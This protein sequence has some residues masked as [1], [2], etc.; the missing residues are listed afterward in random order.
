MATLRRFITGDVAISLDGTATVSNNIFTRIT[1]D[2]SINSNA[3]SLVDNDVYYRETAFAG[4]HV[5]DNLTAQSIPNGTT[6][7]KIVGFKENGLS[8]QCTADATNDKFTF[9]KTGIYLVTG[10]FSFYSGTNNVVWRGACF[11]NN[12]EQNQTHFMRK[13]S[14][15]NDVGNAG[16]TGL[17]NVTTVGHDLDFRVRHDNAGAV[18]FTLEY[19]SLKVLRVGDAQ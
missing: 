15:A 4:M 13:T 6:Y 3:V 9:P 2:V 10:S 16:I 11:L 19:M 14:V 7:T 8:Y 18:N 17:I 12:L 1:G 5:N